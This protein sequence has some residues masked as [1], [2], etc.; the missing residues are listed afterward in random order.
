M[1]HGY[2]AANFVVSGNTTQKSMHLTFQDL[3]VFIGFFVIV[4]GLSVWKSRKA[5]GHEEDS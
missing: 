5:K 2:L 1:F 3:A 4:V